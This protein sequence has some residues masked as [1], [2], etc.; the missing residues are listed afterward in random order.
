MN[1]VHRFEQADAG[2]PP[3]LHSP[4]ES[5][6][7]A[8]RAR[9]QRAD[10]AAAMIASAF[11]GMT[12]ALRP[13]WRTPLVGNNGVTRDALMRCSDRV[14]ADIGIERAHIPLIAQGIDP[15]S[16]SYGTARSGAGGPQ[17]APV[18][19]G[20][21]PPGPGRV[22]Q[23][24]ILGGSMPLATRGCARSMPMSEHA[25]AAARQGL[26]GGAP[27]LPTDGPRQHGRSASVMPPTAE[28]IIA[29]AALARCCRARAAKCPS[30][31]GS[32]EGGSRPVSASSKRCSW[33]IASSPCMKE[34]GC[35]QRPSDAGQERWRA[36][37]CSSFTCVFG[38]AV[39]M[40]RFCNAA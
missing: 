37:P 32:C 15:P 9:Q 35:G 6:H 13:C 27:L 22:L 26:S 18:G 29:A 20:L 14:L 10:A 39:V 24:L 23:E 33:F 11:R 7:F 31:E 17:P 3:A 30:S 4:S 21:G 19:R 8:A 5:G 16:V 2:L 38:T 25:I 34:D 12:G 1:Q 36:H 28:T 40:G